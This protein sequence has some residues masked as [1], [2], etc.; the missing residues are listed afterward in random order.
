M[1]EEITVDQYKEYQKTGRLPD[2]LRVARRPECEDSQGSKPRRTSTPGRMNKTE[3]LYANELESARLAGEI[4]CWI[5]EP[6][7]LRLAKAT[8]YSPDFLVV[9]LDGSM[10]F[11][12][13]KGHWEDDARVKIKC[14]AEKF[15]MFKFLAVT[16]SRG[17]WSTE[18]F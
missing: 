9:H 2:S 14:A 10:A 15:T 16:R 12:E 17:G 5:F 7:K 3:T 6:L 13:V 1:T 18:Q 11:H 4:V 8:Y